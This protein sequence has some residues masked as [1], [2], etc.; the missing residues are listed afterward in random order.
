MSQKTAKRI[1]RLENQM[2]TDKKEAS[3]SEYKFTFEDYREALEGVGPRTREN[4]LARAEQDENIEFPEFVRL[5]KLAY[6]EP[7]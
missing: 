3:M 1:Q 2:I 4:I 5:C 6:P 7:A